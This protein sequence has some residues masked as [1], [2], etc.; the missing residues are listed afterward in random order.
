MLQDNDPDSPLSPP[1]HFKE[2]DKKGAP[3]VVVRDYKTAQE[4]Y[5]ALLEKHSRNRNKHVPGCAHLLFADSCK[6][7]D[8]SKGVNIDIV[9]YTDRKDLSKTTVIRGRCITDQK[10]KDAGIRLAV[11][12]GELP[13]NCRNSSMLAVGEKSLEPYELYKPTEKV[14]EQLMAFGPLIAQ[15]MRKNFPFELDA[16]NSAQYQ[17]GLTPPDFMNGGPGGTVIISK[18]LENEP[19]LDSGDTSRSTVCFFERIPGKA[20]NWAFRFPNLS[21]NGSRGVR[22][23]L[24]DGAVLSYHGNEVKHCTEVLEELG[25]AVRSTE[26]TEDGLKFVLDPKNENSVHGVLFGSL[27]RKKKKKK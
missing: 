15:W 24:C 16:I 6:T 25:F 2:S 20:K 27:L 4:K 18:N 13:G 8:L 9:V 3:Y 23:L 10:V 14:K 1:S 12:G 22:F 11:R 21:I 19:H 7:L 17:K 5:N 26:E